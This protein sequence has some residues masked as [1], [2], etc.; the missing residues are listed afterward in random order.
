VTTTSIPLAEPTTTTA[1]T[2][3]PTIDIIEEEIPKSGEDA[4]LW[5]LGLALIGIA[6]G[7]MLILH[8]SKKNQLA[9]NR[10]QDED[11]D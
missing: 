1:P 10:S 3:I 2:T 5:P 7:L 9:E 8:K 11:S 6:G 4:P